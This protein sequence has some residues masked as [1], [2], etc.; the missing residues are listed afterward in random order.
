MLLGPCKDLFRTATRPEWG[1]KRPLKHQKMQVKTR[2]QQGLPKSSCR[3]YVSVMK[4]NKTISI[5]IKS[6]FVDRFS[7]R[8]DYLEHCMFIIMYLQW[9]EARST[10]SQNHLTRFQKFQVMIKRCREKNGTRLVQ[11]LHSY[12]ISCLLPCIY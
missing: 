12:D 5:E 11:L 1:L 8:E 10:R 7:N 2:Q 3:E 9:D 4:R 6:Q